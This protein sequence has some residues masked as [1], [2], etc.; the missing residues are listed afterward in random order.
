MPT[1]TD[2]IADAMIRHQVYLLRYHR[3]VYTQHAKLID[4]ALADLLMQADKLK[5]PAGSF[6][7]VRLKAMI[8]NIKSWSDGFYKEITDVTASEMKTLAAFE[9]SFAANAIASGFPIVMDVAKVAPAKIHASAMARPFQGR[10]LKDW[11]AGQN[12][13]IQERFKAEIKLGYVQGETLQQIKSRLKG[14][15]NLQKNHLEA[16]VRTALKHTSAVAMEETAMANADILDGEIWVSTLD[17]RT[18]LICQGLDGQEFELGKGPRPPAHISCRSVRVPKTKS[19]KDL[20]FDDL[21]DDDLLSSRPYVR[22]KR[23]VKDIPKDERDNLIGITKSRTYNEWLKAQPRE[24]VNDT[25]GPTR[26]K[27]YLDGNLSLDK[28]TDR[29]GT[30]LTLAELEKKHSAAFERAGL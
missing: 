11:F 29:K 27:L 19:W 12:F 5:T 21:E 14:V 16:V 10:L 15:G 26:A 3:S 30:K 22:D 17:G 28:F 18:S 23:K 6:T 20:G 1:S 7:E 8:D 2:R 25:L 13:S 24:F 4:L 9:S